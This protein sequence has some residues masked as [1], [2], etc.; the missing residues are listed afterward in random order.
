MRVANLGLSP[1]SQAP[2]GGC[3]NMQMIR[4]VLKCPWGSDGNTWV[5]KGLS[6]VILSA[7]SLRTGCVEE[8]EEQI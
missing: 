7:C 6:G 2:Q 4:L 8:C 3:V 1:G 5:G